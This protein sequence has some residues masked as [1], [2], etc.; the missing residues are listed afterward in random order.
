MRNESD[1][2]KF[3][4]KKI[5]KFLSHGQQRRITGILDEK[6]DSSPAEVSAAYIKIMQEVREMIKSKRLRPETCDPELEIHEDIES[7]LAQGVCFG[8][9]GGPVLAAVD[10]ILSFTKPVAPT[11]APSSGASNKQHAEELADLQKRVQF[12]TQENNNLRL[13]VRTLESKLEDIKKMAG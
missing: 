3:I 2:L 8:K 12:M 4:L 5:F 7:L 13:R 9:A 1:I 11:S 10:P 6:K